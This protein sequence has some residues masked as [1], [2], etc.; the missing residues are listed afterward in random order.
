MVN[1]S[2]IRP[3]ISWGKRP[4]R[5]PWIM[6]LPWK[7]LHHHSTSV[8]EWCQ[9]QCLKGRCSSFV[10]QWITRGDA[11]Y[12]AQP[13]GFS[14]TGL[15]WGVMDGC[16]WHGITLLVGGFN[17]FEK[18]A[19]QI[20]SSPQVGICRDKHKKCLKPF[21]PPFVWQYHACERAWH[22]N[23]WNHHLEHHG[24]RRAAPNATL[25]EE[26]RPSRDGKHGHFGLKFFFGIK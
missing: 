21:V 16:V 12:T 9:L 18:Y 20:G 6:R 24:N 19:R 17:P 8:S 3:A 10:T 2:L 4:L 23:V 26:I 15:W 22:F 25:P 7:V 11:W 1:R 5:F 13:G 14:V